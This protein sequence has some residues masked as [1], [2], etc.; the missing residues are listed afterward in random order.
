MIIDEV[1]GDEDGADYI[2]QPHGPMCN[3]SVMQ[4]PTEQNLLSLDIQEFGDTEMVV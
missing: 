3:E 1:V 2:L 4:L